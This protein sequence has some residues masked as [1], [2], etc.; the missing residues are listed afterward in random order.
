MKT[1]A[2]RLYGKQDLR[3]EEFDLPDIREDEMLARVVTDGICM[4]SY[5]AA[6]QGPDHKRIPDDVA[7]N[8]VIIG[9]EMC[10][11]ILQVGH[12][13]R[14]RFQKG[15]RFAIQANLNHP[16]LPF[17]AP[18]YSFPYIGGCAQ[19][20]IIPR[21][22]LDMDCVLP[23]KGNSFF[24]GSLAEPMSCII[25]AFHAAYHIGTNAY[26]HVMGVKP[27]GNM[28]ILAGAGPMGLGAIDYA[29]NHITRPRLLVVTDINRERLDRAKEIFPPHWA[30]E[31]GVE[32][33]YVNTMDHGEPRR[34]L[35]SLAGNTGYD[36]VFV[37]APVRGLVEQADGILGH[38]GCLNFFAGPTDKEF[39]ALLNFYHVHY[40][41][42]HIVGTSGGNTDDMRECIRLCEEGI[43][44]PSSMVTHIGGMDA[45]AD[46]TLRLPE[47]PGGKKLIYTGIRLPLT[48]L[49]DFREKGYN[50]LADICDRNRG[51][52]CGE[53]E[54]YLL[55]YA[56][57]L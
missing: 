32:L 37:F 24:E 22:V 47:I 31:K 9:H 57:K 52:W 21:E 48:A 38:D 29:V 14:D 30:R 45:A 54:Q 50:E 51:L 40:S 2:L 39:S 35:L 42:T 8:P 19:H 25:G 49:M 36:D 41:A 33:V 46:T 20:I 11:E 43:L 23:Y 13:W 12:V 4:S 5:K 44:T 17:A 6:I 28:A 7:Q 3:L 55:Q 18:G 15:D 16:D 27:G 53:A 56:E 1:K 26:S 10:G 34:F